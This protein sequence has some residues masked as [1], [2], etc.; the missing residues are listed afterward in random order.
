MTTSSRQVVHGIE[1]RP[2]RII[3]PMVVAPVS[4]AEGREQVVN[5]ARK[6]IQQHRAVLVAL[7]DR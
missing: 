5:S 4:T 3:K 1:L 6:V 2:R 7:K